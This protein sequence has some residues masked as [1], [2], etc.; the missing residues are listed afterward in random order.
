MQSVSPRSAVGVAGQTHLPCALD[1]LVQGR[2]QLLHCPV[3]FLFVGNCNR[4]FNQIPDPVN[5]RHSTT[6]AGN[7]TPA[8]H[9]LIFIRYRVQPVVFLNRKAVERPH[10]YSGW[11]L[12]LNCR[13]R[14]ITLIDPRMLCAR[15]GPGPAKVKIRSAPRWEGA[16]CR[17]YTPPP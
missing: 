6:P 3:K 17:P 16:F 15:A 9:R 8:L 2:P 12:L 7:H 4:L 14:G 10:P 1:V 11:A 13:N 5:A